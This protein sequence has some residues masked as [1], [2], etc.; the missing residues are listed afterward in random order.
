MLVQ[1]G[2][3]ARARGAGGASDLG[4]D[5]P[6]GSGSAFQDK[7][8]RVLEEKVPVAMVTQ[9][10]PQ[11]LETGAALITHN[12]TRVVSRWTEPRLHAQMHAPITEALTP[13]VVAEVPARVVE[14]VV[15][16]THALLAGDLAAGLARALPAALAPA[17]TELVHYRPERDY[18]CLLCK[19]KQLYCAWCPQDGMHNLQT[20]QA[21]Y[22]AAY[23]SSYGAAWRGGAARMAAEGGGSGSG[24]GA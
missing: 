15:E 9:M 23:Y 4:G 10:M 6:G 16:D 7:V 24:G 1:T 20:L 3:R 22:Y 21:A 5:A 12:A 19:K 14:R 17:V 18:Y 2:A 8:A 11:L 13:R